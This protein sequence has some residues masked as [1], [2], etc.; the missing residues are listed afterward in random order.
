MLSRGIFFFILSTTLTAAQPGAA[1]LAADEPL[2]FTRGHHLAVLTTRT[3][4]KPRPPVRFDV[5]LIGHRQVDHGLNLYSHKDEQVFGNKLADLIEHQRDLITDPLVT[6]YI[7]RIED[8]ISSNSD[9]HSLIKVKILKDVEA[10]AYSVPGFIY[11]QSGL[12]LAAEN[13][14]QLVAALSHE[15]AHV[16]GRH[17]TRFLSQ[18][19]IWKWSSLIAGGP[20][21]YVFGRKAAPFFFMRSLRN[22][23][24]EADLLGLQYVYASGYDPTEFVNLVES[25][26]DDEEHPSFRERLSDSHPSAEVRISKA[27]QCIRNYLPMRAEAVVD[28][29]EFQEVKARVKML[30]GFGE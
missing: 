18:Q 15:T 10:N 11:L 16:A 13:E 17:L 6:E 4:R 8:R 23:E 19:R 26:F 2:S 3:E 22:V 28:T 9:T 30:M 24:L 5:S 25:L 14:A 21:G 29:S 1:L 27:Q 12:I 7:E 20:V